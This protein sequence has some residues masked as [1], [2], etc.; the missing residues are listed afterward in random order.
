[1]KLLNLRHLARPGTMLLPIPQSVSCA[2][3]A[4]VERE[5]AADQAEI[6]NEIDWIAADVPLSTFIT[7]MEH[8]NA[9]YRL[10]CRIKSHTCN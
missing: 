3:L 7:K 1:M 4:R 8:I 10:Y 2:I 9:Y 6:L 5:F